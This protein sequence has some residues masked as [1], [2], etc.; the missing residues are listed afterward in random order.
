MCY[1]TH[2]R[3]LRAWTWRRAVKQSEDP[4]RAEPR[5]EADKHPLQPVALDKV[6]SREKEPA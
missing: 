3:L 1:E 6:Q 5:R 4:N 2:E